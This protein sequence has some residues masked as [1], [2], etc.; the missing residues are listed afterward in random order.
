MV[1]RLRPFTPDD[2]P[3]AIEIGNRIFP[4]SPRSLK[5]ALHWDSRWAT[6]KYFRERLVADDGTGHVLGVAS[7]HHMPW[8]FSPDSYGFGA[9]VDP[10]RQRQG[11]GSTLFE[12]LLETARQRGA[13]L[14]RAEAKESKP[15]SLV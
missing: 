2:W 15:E 10:V 11:I 8:Q 4:D 6:E 7:L 13:K 1:I 14:I 9:E 12:A 3:A 5:G